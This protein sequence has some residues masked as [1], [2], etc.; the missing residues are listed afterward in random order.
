MRELNTDFTARLMISLI[1]V[2]SLLVL[3]LV[4]LFVIVVVRYKVKFKR[5]RR[6]VLFDIEL[7]E[8]DDPLA[9]EEKKD[10]EMSLDPVS[11][12]KRIRPFDATIF[13]HFDRDDDF[14]LNH[15]LPELEETRDF[16]LCIHSRNFV[17]GRDIKDNIEEAIEGQ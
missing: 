5:A 14:V 6:E 11:P 4:A 8:L 7:K 10:P 13:Y 9:Q 1:V 15:L 17:P 16:K 3:I 2:A 12:S